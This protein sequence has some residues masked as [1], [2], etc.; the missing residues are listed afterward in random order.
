[1]WGGLDLSAIGGAVG[2]ALKNAQRDLDQVASSALGIDS[3]KENTNAGS[4]SG[5]TSC[6]SM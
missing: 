5:I 3:T 6:Q 2:E 1:M 4:S